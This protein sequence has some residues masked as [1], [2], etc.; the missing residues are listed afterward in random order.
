M[1]FINKGQVR[2]QFGGVSNGTIDRWVDEG[3]LPKPTFK[4]WRRRW[5]Y[6]E[7]LNVLKVKRAEKKFD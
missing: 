6:E 1:T 4:F 7:L 3:K 5:N 2:Q